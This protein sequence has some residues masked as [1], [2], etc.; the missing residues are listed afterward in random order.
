M[1]SL[2]NLRPLKFNNIMLAVGLVAVKALI[3]SSNCAPSGK[4]V[5]IR[6][7][8][9]IA[10]FQGP[11]I[12]SAIRSNIAYYV[13]YPL[14]ASFSRARGFLDIVENLVIKDVHPAPSQH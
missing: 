7:H 6:V 4:Q 8:I 12:G 13:S 3:I 5:F 9:E 14:L 1:Q 10:A 11:A 2:T